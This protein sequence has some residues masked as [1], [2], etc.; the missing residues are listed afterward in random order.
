MGHR[1]AGG[2]RVDGQTPFQ[3]KEDTLLQHAARGQRAHGDAGRR[4]PASFTYTY[5]ATVIDGYSYGLNYGFVGVGSDNSRGSMDNATVQILPPQFTSERPR[6]STP[7]PATSARPPARGARPAAATTGRAASAAGPRLG[8][9]LG[10]NA[11]AELETSLRTSATAGIVFDA[12]AANDYKFAA[13]DMAGQRVLLGHV[14]PRRGF[15]IDAAV[16]RVLISGAETVSRS[17]SPP[18]GERPRRRSDRVQLR[19]QRRGHRR[20]R[21]PD[22]AGRLRLVRPLPAAGPTTGRSQARRCRP[23]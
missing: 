19:V 10:T 21:R 12:Y 16:A 6:A 3:P 8:H 15:V 5:R 18:D 2:W 20:R 9:G 11:H 1:D 22:G 4:Q 13:L 23:F 7:A 14:D 17:S